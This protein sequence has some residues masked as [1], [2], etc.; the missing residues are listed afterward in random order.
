MLISGFQ[1]RVLVSVLSEPLQHEG[2]LRL[3]PFIIPDKHPSDGPN[4][5]SG[6]IEDLSPNLS[7]CGD[8]ESANTMTRGHIDHFAHLHFVKQNFDKMGRALIFFGPNTGIS[9]PLNFQLPSSD[10]CL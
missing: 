7:L 1:G 5:A 10:L 8:L 9:S 4:H 3:C 6:L 2:V